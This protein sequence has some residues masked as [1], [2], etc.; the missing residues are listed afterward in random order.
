[1]IQ[2][3]DL[4]APTFDGRLS[5]T[6]YSLS[7]RHM[8]DGYSFSITDTDNV[9]QLVKFT[10]I[11]NR[12]A[13]SNAIKAL[14]SDPLLQQQYLKI[15]YYQYGTYSINPAIF[16]EMNMTIPQFAGQGA[17]MTS[18]KKDLVTQQINAQLSICYT[19][20]STPCTIP[21]SSQFHYAQLLILAALN[22]PTADAVWAETLPEVT[23]I[24][25]KSHHKLLLANTYPTASQTDA[26]YHILACYEMTGLSQTDT[27]LFLVDATNDRPESIHEILKPYIYTINPLTPQLWDN[28]PEEYTGNNRL[29]RFILQTI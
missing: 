11:N 16:N 22:H 23:T 3:I 25:I 10:G 18:H 13:S 24:A 9:C 2:N 7:I 8:P 5:A 12:S 6:Q 28:L 1:M 26:V 21:G 4:I 14:K 17:V 19:P 20:S 29:N 15:N 27:P